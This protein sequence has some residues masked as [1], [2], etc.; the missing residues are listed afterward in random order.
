LFLLSR[1]DGSVAGFVNANVKLVRVEKLAL[2]L[3]GISP[4]SSD[5]NRRCSSG[6]ESRSSRYLI[7]DARIVVSQTESSSKPSPLKSIGSIGE[8]RGDLDVSLARVS[9]SI[10]TVSISSVGVSGITGGT[11]SNLVAVDLL[12]I[13]I[14]YGHVVRLRSR[15]P[16]KS[17]ETSSMI[18]AGPLD[19]DSSSS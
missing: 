19:V 14:E 2:V 9:G 15:G 12:N 18:I 13:S 10:G 3:S 16:S 11:S 7:I 1:I 5:K 17:N 6:S 4:I 8:L